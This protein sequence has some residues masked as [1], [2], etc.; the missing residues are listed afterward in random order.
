VFR[1]FRLPV[2]LL[3]GALI[4]S[5]EVPAS[6]QSNVVVPPP[7]PREGTVG[8]EQLRDFS[9]GGSN[10]QR[11]EPPEQSAPAPSA[12]APT[13]DRPPAAPSTERRTATPGTNSAA[14]R[15]TVA[16]R[17]PDSGASAP[18][19]STG[20]A[21]TT[22]LALPPPTPAPAASFD[23]NSPGLGS[24][25]AGSTVP[26]LPPPV[27]EEDGAPTWPWLLAFAAVVAGGLFLWSRRRAATED[28][29]EG[30]ALA[31]AGAAPTPS[32]PQP[33]APRAGP[34]AAQP[35]P[36]PV[37]SHPKGVGIVSTRLRP[38]LDL[39]VHVAT[40]ALTEEE[41]QLH[42]Q[43]VVANSGSVPARQVGVEVVPLNA[44]P[45]QERELAT[46]FARPDPQPQAAEMIAPL[47]RAVLQTLV[48]MPRSAFREYAAGEGRVLVPLVALNVVYRAGNSTGRTS[49]AYLIGRGTANS[50]KLG[51][52]RTDPGPREF[53]G[54]IARPLT[55]GIRR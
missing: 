5:A 42:L 35:A 23:F 17:A 51:P 32:E 39:E 24:P 30:G 6:A 11:A 43:L 9:L 25:P 47:D 38:W 18:A 22:S 54:V 50:E 20:A 45:E 4:A 27:T 53:R 41:L 44:G 29:L 21:P 14:G 46:F 1:G 19:P 15:T 10:T 34:P 52:L 36:A 48:R 7:P 55:G 26:A 28:Q 33:A 2:L 13:P 8:P 37:P 12:S 40:A 3:A 16:E 31:F 49:A